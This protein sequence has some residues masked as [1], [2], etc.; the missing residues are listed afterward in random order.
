MNFKNINQE[1]ENK[2]LLLKPISKED[3]GFINGLFNEPKIKF[4]YIVPKEAK[5]DYKNLV[6][7]WLNDIKNGAGTCWVIHKIGSGFFSRNKKVGFIAFEF[8]KKIKNAQVS[9]AISSKYRREGIALAAAKLVIGRLKNE[10][11][12]Q[13]TADIDK[14]NVGS[15]K[16][17]EKLGFKTNKSKAL[18][19]PEMMRNGDVR[20]RHLW[21]KELI[22]SDSNNTSKPKK[23]PLNAVKGDVIPLIDKLE[24]K[25]NNKGNQPNLLARYFY[26]T[27][28]LK[29]IEEKYDEAQEAFKQSNMIVMNGGLP[30]VHENFYWFG[31]INEEKGDLGDARMYYS[32]ALEKY[33]EDPRYITK[34]EIKAELTK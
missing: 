34:S 20:L 18:V 32:F 12:E 25:I 2:E 10:G 23:V 14:D 21:K 15:I 5:Q 7:Y 8:R 3:F 19:D 17:V 1:L 11:V 24:K 16:L 29:F 28:R 6:K 30:E 31:R 26:L 4:F 27:G 33:N 13:I 22:E 9:Y